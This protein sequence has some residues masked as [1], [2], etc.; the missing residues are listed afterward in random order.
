MGIKRLLSS[1]VYT[2]AY[3]LHDGPNQTSKP[4]KTDRQVIHIYININL[5]LKLVK[6]LYS[7]KCPSIC[8]FGLRGNAIFSA[9]Y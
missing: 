5:V 2:A 1:G 4:D 3:P 6:L 9:P 8:P 7:Y